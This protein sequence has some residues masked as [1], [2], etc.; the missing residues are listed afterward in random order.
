[1]IAMEIT[2]DT[3][4]NA[5]KLK[6]LLKYTKLGMIKGTREE[7]IEMVRIGLI[8]AIA[9]F[10]DILPGY[11]IRPLTEVERQAK[12]SKDVRKQRT[13]EETLLRSYS[14]YVERLDEIFRLEGM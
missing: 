12:V 13:I 6:E 5:G 1:M 11:S 9:V 7:E 14:Q 4:E 10:K 8:T 2:E 3:D